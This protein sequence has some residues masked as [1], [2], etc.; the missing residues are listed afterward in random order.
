MVQIV[1]LV[2]KL[3][4]P[5]MCEEQRIQ[6][7]FQG[8]LQQCVFAAQTYLAQWVGEHPQWTIKNFHCEYPRGGDRAEDTE[9]AP[10]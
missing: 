2:C 10:K 9:Q 7:A 4:Q 3:A 1:M 6:F 5:D 8:S